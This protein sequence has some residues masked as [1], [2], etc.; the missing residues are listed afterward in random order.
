[1]K[2]HL[3]SSSARKKLEETVELAERDTAGDIV[4]MIVER[5]QNIGWI[6]FVAGFVGGMIGVCI[7]F[8]YSYSSLFPVDPI[9]MIEWISIAGMVGVFV[10]FCP[11]V[12]RK[13][14]GNHRLEARVDE[15]AH[16]LFLQQGLADTEHRAAV[17]IFV[18]LFERKI[19]IL[20]DRAIHQKV[21]Q[22]K[23]NHLAQSLSKRF[24][25]KD[26][27]RGL[28]DAIHSVGKLLAEYIPPIQGQGHEL[29]A[30]VRLPNEE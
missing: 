12:Q 15:R 24:K 19:R 1:M 26:A 16:A 27:V 8:V 7:A 2:K 29:S 21:G 9:R 18:S 23:W 30:K 10:G 14:L 17:L 5:S 25:E 4:P 22:E 6:P 3:L 11:W 28:E 20:S 13:L